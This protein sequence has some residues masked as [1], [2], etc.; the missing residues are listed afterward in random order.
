[1][2]TCIGGRTASGR[3]ELVSIAVDPRHRGKG[4]ASVLMAS[5]LRR[6]RRRGVVRVHLMVKVTNKIAIRFYE[7]YGFHKSRI[8]R[9]YYED[10]ADAW[11]MAK[12]WNSQLK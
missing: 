2:V 12:C 8:V 3:A 7:Q 1:M 10:G 11:R 4:I 9:G 5:T 6:L